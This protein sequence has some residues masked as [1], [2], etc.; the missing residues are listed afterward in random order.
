MST[1]ASIFFLQDVDRD[2]WRRGSGAHEWMASRQN[3]RR[4]RWFRARKPILRRLGTRVARAK[5]CGRGLDFQSPHFLGGY[6]R[7]CWRGVFPFFPKNHRLGRE[8][9]YSWRCSYPFAPLSV[10]IKKEKGGG[11]VQQQLGTTGRDS[12]RV[13]NGYSVPRVQNINTID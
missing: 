13:W 12:A 11:G 2:G 7:S 3:K 10:A 4:V 6:I 8:I 1:A 5:L 9:G